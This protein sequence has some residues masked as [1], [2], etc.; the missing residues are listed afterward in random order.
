MKLAVPKNYLW[1]KILDRSLDPSK[2][3]V[4]VILVNLKNSYTLGLFFL[5]KK[6]KNFITHFLHEKIDPSKL[7]SNFGPIIIIGCNYGKYRGNDF[8]KKNLLWIS[9]FI[10]EPLIC[11][12]SPF[13]NSKI[14]PKARILENPLLTNIYWI[15]LIK[16]L[17]WKKY[18]KDN[19]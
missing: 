19:L 8:R 7:F 18:W 15:G 13:F 5:K 12:I 10:N 3:G 4:Y 17:V 11:I 9:W 1:G 16:Y 2:N 6:I 14:Q